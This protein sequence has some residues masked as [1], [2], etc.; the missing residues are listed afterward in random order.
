MAAREGYA[1]IVKALIERAKTIEQELE[2][3]LGGAVKK[4]LRA[5]NVNGDTA[6]HVAVRNCHLEKDKYLE[7]VKLLTR[8]DPEFQH[9]ANNANETPLYLAAERGNQG[10]AVLLTILETCTSPTYGGPGG[11]TALHAA[12]LNDF[13]GQSIRRLLEWKK[14]LIEKVDTCGW[15][16]LH[17]AAYNGNLEGVKQLLQTDES[18]GYITTT[19]KDGLEAALHMATA[20]GHVSVMEELLSSNP[21]CWEMVNSKGQNVL[22]IAV[23]MED[24]S[25]IKFILNKPWLRHLINQKD[26]EGNTP[27][28]LLVSSDSEVYELWEHHR[29]DRHAFNDKNMT[30]ADIGW[31]TFEDARITTS[32]KTLFVDRLLDSQNLG[33]RYIVSNV[34]DHIVKLKRARKHVK[35]KSK[36][37][38]EA[39]EQR[40]VEERQTKREGVIRSF[41]TLVIVAALIATISFAAAFAIPGGYDGNQ[42]RHQGLAVLAKTAAFKAFVITNTITVVCSV[43]SI[44]LCFMALFYINQPDSK[45]LINL[46][47]GPAVILMLEPYSP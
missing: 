25:V 36:I 1:N 20:R 28:H 35:E 27:L 17:C 39:E 15:T 31:S 47:L 29:A 18:A 13:T 8:E 10:V 5:T 43:T 42:G 24:E 45:K 6:L 40:K 14:D 21:D 46:R 11:R 2:S 7:V 41:Q 37:I 44:F 32:A 12:T 34:H 23:A 4:M 33:K 9:A 16:P 30:P 38:K 22:H 26:N 3:G 19:K